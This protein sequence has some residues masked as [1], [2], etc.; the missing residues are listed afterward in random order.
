MLDT[1]LLALG[2]SYAVS[3]V[4]PRASMAYFSHMSVRCL[5]GPR[6]TKMGV[7]A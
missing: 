3:Y 7:A 6:T 5:I 2:A 1:A 4:A